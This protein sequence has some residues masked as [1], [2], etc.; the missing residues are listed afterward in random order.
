MCRTLKPIADDYINF[1]VVGKRI[2]IPY[3]IVKT[4]KEIPQPFDMARTDEY[5]NVAAKGTPEQIRKVLNACTR[6]NNFSLQKHSAQEITDFMV[7]KGIGID[8]SGFVYHVLDRYIKKYRHNSLEKIIVRSPGLVGKIERWLL[9]KNRVRRISGTTLT[10][11]LN[12]IK[13]K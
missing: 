12:T 2:Q 1:L 13:I 5:T 6:K 4:P 10:S 8:C 11:D 9:R 7:E 3:C